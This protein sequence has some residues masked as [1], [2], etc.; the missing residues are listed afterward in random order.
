MKI[1]GKQITL[2]GLIWT[3]FI[4]ILGGIT[5]PLLNDVGHYSYKRLFKSGDT[6]ARIE[7]LRQRHEEDLKVWADSVRNSLDIKYAPELKHLTEELQR[8]KGQPG[9]SGIES[10]FRQK[11]NSVINKKDGEFK[12]LLE[13]KKREQKREIE[14]LELE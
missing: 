5:T 8:H 11:I 10:Y 12:T 4:F 6:K 13:I 9:L 3:I 2:R 7:R 14:D 1:A